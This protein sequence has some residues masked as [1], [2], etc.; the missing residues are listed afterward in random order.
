MN[1]PTAIFISLLMTSGVLTGCSSMSG[2]RQLSPQKTETQKV[3]KESKTRHKPSE[4]PEQVEN[5]QHRLSEKVLSGKWTIHSV[6]DINVTGNDEQW[7]Y[8]EFDANTDR[9]YAS[10]GCNILNGRFKVASGQQINMTDIVASRRSCPEN[11]YPDINT[12]LTQVRAYSLSEHNGEYYLSLHNDRH[13]TVMLLRKH[14]MDYLNGPW[15]VTEI[16]DRKCQSNDVKIVIDIPEGLIHGNT[17][18]NI[19]N[20][21]L[22]E[23]PVKTHS[24]QFHNIVT[25]R[26]ACSDVSAQA[27]EMALLIAL[28]EVE[29]AKAGSHGTVKLLD[30]RNRQVLRLSPITNE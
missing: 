21:R 28:E 8:I 15:R 12:Q 29:Y 17:G 22:Y 14:N 9:F 24:I 30:K 7:P 16:N 5:E 13:I 20:G 10:N 11:E 19:L 6:G 26:T 1:R 23:D 4:S 25:T 18:C 3:K 2:F 27:T